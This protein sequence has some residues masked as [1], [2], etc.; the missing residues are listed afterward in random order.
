MDSYNKSQG[1]DSDA[2]LTLIELIRV[3][4][5]YWIV[6]VSVSLTILVTAVL[7]AFLSTPIYRAEV[8]IAA[9]D[10]NSAGA[11]GG[12][13]SV[14]SRLGAIPGLGGISRLARQDS[15]A[16]GIVTLSSPKFTMEFISDRNLLP[17]LFA[18]KWNAVDNE[19]DIDDPLDIPTLSDGYLLFTKNILEIVEEDNG[20]VTLSIEWSDPALSAEWANELVS[21][22]NEK[23]R[24]RA[25]A[26]ANKTID[27][28][29]KEAEKTRIVELR[30]A[31]YYMIETQINLRTMANVREEFAF[32]VISP[33]VVPEDDRFVYPDRLF[34]LMLAILLGPILGIFAAFLLFSVSRIRSELASI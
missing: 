5:E 22:I 9:A 19:W 31:I 1:R 33:A 6:V 26:E 11:G 10:D 24:V 17:I 28:L 14:M 15:T 21:R 13:S 32:K 3:V 16:Q 18:G 4:K 34:I 8:L 7:F 29:N 2:E 23:L 25:I 12:L 27:Y 30:Q 20:I